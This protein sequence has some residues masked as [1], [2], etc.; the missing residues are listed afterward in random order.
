MHH[1]LLQVFAANEYKQHGDTGNSF[2]LEHKMLT[3]LEWMGDKQHNTS[4]P[5]QKG[6]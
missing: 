1:I 6:L 3:W 4:E 2:F 5:Q